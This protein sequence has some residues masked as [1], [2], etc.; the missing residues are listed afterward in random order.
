MSESPRRS[1]AGLHSRSIKDQILQGKS[2][3]SRKKTGS[4]SDFEEINDTIKYS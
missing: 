2:N 3:K 4:S 1:I